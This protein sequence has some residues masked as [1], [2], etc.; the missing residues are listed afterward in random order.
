MRD[1]L[2]YRKGAVMKIIPTLFAVVVI[3]LVAAVSYYIGGSMQGTN[4]IRQ[5][6][7]TP[8]KETKQSEPCIPNYQSKTDNQRILTAS[9]TKPPAPGYLTGPS[10]PNNRAS[11]T[12]PSPPQDTVEDLNL[13]YK[14]DIAELRYEID[15]LRYEIE[16]LKR[17]TETVNG[18][19]VDDATAQDYIEEARRTGIQRAVKK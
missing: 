12:L 13:R 9:D 16:K 11:A 2:F 10:Q 18:V 17:K 8:V 19:P 6:I 14:R 15:E 3:M 4:S 1:I 7:H 5:S